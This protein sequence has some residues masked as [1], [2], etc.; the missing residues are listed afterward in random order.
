MSIKNVYDEIASFNGLL[1]ANHDIQLGR[2]YN[3]EEL[4]YWQHLETNTHNIS[5]MLYAGEYPPDTYR[6]FYVYE[7]K[8]GKSSVV[9][10]S[11]S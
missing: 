6:T 2:R 7:P 3:P 11:P 4:D 5:N 9:I 8:F 1:R 10:T